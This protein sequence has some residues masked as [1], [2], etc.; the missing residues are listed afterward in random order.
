METGD[1][2][3]ESP[4]NSE[5]AR[6]DLYWLAL[7]I[8]SVGEEERKGRTSE[9]KAEINTSPRTALDCIWHS[10]SDPRA[11]PMRQDRDLRRLQIPE[12]T[13]YNFVRS[14]ALPSLGGGCFS[15]S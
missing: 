6:G 5:I 10:G 8:G 13:K 15:L 4:M 14:A 1:D 9:K 12:S 3:T 2:Q 11:S 7:S